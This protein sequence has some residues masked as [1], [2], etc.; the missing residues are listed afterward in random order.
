MI[1]TDAAAVR[2]TQRAYL[3]LERDVATGDP[4]YTADELE[5]MAFEPD[6]VTRLA[7][8]RPTATWRRGD[9]HPRFRTP[10]RFSG[11][12][13]ELPARETHVTE[14]VLSDLLDA[15]EPYAE[16]LAAARDGLGLRAGIMILIEMQGDRDEDGDVSV[17]TASIAYSAATL[18]RLAALDLSLEHDQYVLV[19]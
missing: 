13:Y 5:L 10:R 1:D 18:H 4:P 17:S 11:W 3:Y 16:G 7:G 14:H 15:V 19:D 2:C 12:H 8:L 6:E 9:P